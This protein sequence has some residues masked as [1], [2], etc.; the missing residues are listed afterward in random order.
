ARRQRVLWFGFLQLSPPGEFPGAS[1]SDGEYVVGRAEDYHL[2]RFLDVRFSGDGE[3]VG[4]LLG[5]PRTVQAPLASTLAGG[6]RGAERVD[7]AG[8]GGEQRIG[9]LD[10]AP[11]VGL[12]PA[13]NLCGV[14]HRAV[15]RRPHTDD[16]R[17]GEHLEV[18]HEAVIADYLIDLRQGCGARA[19]KGEE[20]FLIV[21]AE[22]RDAVVAV[23]GQVVGE[24]DNSLADRLRGRGVAVLVGDSRSEEHT[25]E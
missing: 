8:L 11:L 23:L 2:V 16:L 17:L 22:A 4:G 13:V 3:D 1:L 25:S 19:G 15:E 14:N 20:D 7:T 21:L 9:A 12:G 18:R 24:L 5:N 10:D 6:H